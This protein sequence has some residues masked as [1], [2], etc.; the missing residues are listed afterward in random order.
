LISDECYTENLRVQDF[1]FDKGIVT[2]YGKGRKF[3]I[4]PLPKGETSELKDHPKRI[5]NLHCQ[6]LNKELSV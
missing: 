5:K 2:I 6:N 3:R 1:D 4:V